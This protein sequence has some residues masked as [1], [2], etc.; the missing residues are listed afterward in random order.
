MVNDYDEFAKERQEKLLKGETKS[1]R[2]SE[3]PMMKSMLSSLKRKRILM[4]G[5][6]TGEESLLLKEFGAS[7]II[8]MDLSSKSIKIA[9]ET[10]PDIEF[11]VGDMH[12]LP[13]EDESFDF[14]YSSLAIHYSSEPK[15]VY[16]E[17]Y[18]VL[19]KNGQLLF[20]VGH[21]LRWASEH[22]IVDDVEYHIS[23]YAYPSSEK[24]VFGNYSTFASHNHYFPN[25]EVLSF[26][27]G[28][29]S[30]HFGLLRECG[31]SIEDF[32]ESICIDEAKEVDYN[33]WLKNHEIPQF[34][35]FLVQK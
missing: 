22:M 25:G 19:K 30:F 18:R 16:Q 32:K 26:Y 35:A 20:S 34:M 33:Y 23:G 17:I 21:P 5:C 13:F 15:Q 7:D 28:S 10:Y 8:G 29:P 1:H 12:D 2:F 24:R 6:G 27:V 31:F 9:K 14:V 4:L 11:L 3:K